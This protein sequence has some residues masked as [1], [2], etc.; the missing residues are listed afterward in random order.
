MLLDVASFSSLVTVGWAAAIAICVLSVARAYAR[1]K[2]AEV[3]S[4]TADAWKARAEQKELEAKE[5]REL[6]HNALA[7]LAA[8]RMKTDLTEVMKF[9][10]DLGEQI[11]LIA[12][13]QERSLSVIIALERRLN[14]RPR[15]L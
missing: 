4:D 2:T 8:Q 1:Q 5:Q 15:S 6:K 13:S 14:D 7:E 11:R 10:A 12:E 3:Y 9:M